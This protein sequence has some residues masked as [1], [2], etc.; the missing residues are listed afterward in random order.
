MFVLRDV[1]HQNASIALMNSACAWTPASPRDN[2][3]S[4][5]FPFSAFCVDGATP[6]GR[7]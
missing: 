4:E 1:S 2:A 3:P 7:A 6:K 5:P